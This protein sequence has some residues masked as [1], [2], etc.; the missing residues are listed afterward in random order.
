MSLVVASWTM[1]GCGDHKPNAVDVHAVDWRTAVLPGS[2]CGAS[3]PIRLRDGTAIVRSTRWRPYRR[4]HVDTRFARVAYGDLDGDGR[5]EAA[6]G[7]DCD[8]GGGTADGVFAYA[9]VLFVADGDAPRVLGVVTP[10]RHAL[11][12]AYPTLLQVSIKR[13]AVIARESWYRR[14]DVGP[15]CPSGRSTTIWTD[16][17]KR[18]RVVATVVQPP[19]R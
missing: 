19:R 6:L 18:L 3:Q 4:I 14:R 5:D 8:N 12:H 2:I 13:G 17:G 9:R 11:P 10:Q 1:L 15:C 16:G 7:V